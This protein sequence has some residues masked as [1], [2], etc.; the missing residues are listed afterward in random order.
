M[1]EA[2]RTYDRR[3]SNIADPRYQ[4]SKW[5]ILTLEQYIELEPSSQ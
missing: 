4:W 2:E 5:K 1:F 3:G